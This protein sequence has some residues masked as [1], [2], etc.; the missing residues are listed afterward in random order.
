MK[1]ETVIARH[2]KGFRLDWTG[3]VGRGKTG[4]PAVPREVRDLIR[5]MS[6]NN[7][8]WGAPRIHGELLKLGIEITEPTVAKLALDLDGHHFERT[9][10]QILFRVRGRC[11]P[12]RFASFV[13]HSLDFAV[14]TLDAK[15]LI[16]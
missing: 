14:R 13:F 11:S 1:P 5:M 7:P 9:I 3:K 4:R 10:A 6:R 12:N 8:M 16:G 2:R 15:L